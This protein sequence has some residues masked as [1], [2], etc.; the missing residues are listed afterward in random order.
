[1]QV[2]ELLKPFPIKEF[3]PFPRALMGPGA[4]EMIG[5]EALKM[6]FRKTLVMTSGLRGTDIVHKSVESMKYHGLESWSTTRWSP[7]P[8][9]T[10]SWTR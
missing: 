8:R 7:T 5:S 9:T 4:R 1:M 2:D 3:L 10:T 6:G